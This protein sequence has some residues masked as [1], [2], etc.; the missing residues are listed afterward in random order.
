MIFFFRHFAYYMN[1]TIVRQCLKRFSSSKSCK[2]SLLFSFI[3]YHSSR[4]LYI[5][6][7]VSFYSKDNSINRLSL[8]SLVFSRCRCPWRI[9][10]VRFLG[11]SG[12]H[13]WLPQSWWSSQVY[14]TQ[15]NARSLL[16][17]WH[18]KKD[19]W[20]INSKYRGQLC[21][22]FPCLF[23]KLVLYS[24]MVGEMVGERDHHEVPGI[25]AVTLACS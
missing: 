11:R 21:Y 1:R 19:G 3:I 4:R 20:D 18:G 15:P 14:R 23:S 8:T 25:F 24:R 2:F 22:T 10:P 12:R 7:H 6:V 13:D 17:K 16:Q 5:H 9:R